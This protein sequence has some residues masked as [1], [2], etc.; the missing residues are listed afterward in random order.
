[1]VTSMWKVFG[2]MSVLYCE[3]AAW[4]L[5]SGDA[6]RATSLVNKA[7]AC[8]VQRVRHKQSDAITLNDVLRER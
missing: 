3:A 7:H 4:V 8:L 2:Q 6:N 5:A 1:M